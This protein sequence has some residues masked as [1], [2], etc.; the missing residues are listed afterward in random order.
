LLSAVLTGVASFAATNVDD[1]FLLMLFFSQVDEK[2]RA[3]HIVAGQYMGFAALVGLSLLGSLG[4][5]V[6]PGEWVGLLGVVPIYLG[7]RALL[8]LRG[9]RGESGGPVGVSGAWG[10]AAVTFANGA[11]NLGVY[12][13]LFAGA[14]PA[15]TG[16][17]VFVFFVL[18]A[19]WCFAGHRLGSHPAVAEK[20]DRYGHVV[21]PFVLM[22][23][24]VYILLEA[25]SPSLLV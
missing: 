5:L 3:W 11:D 4:A 2:F 14:G 23:L 19:L 13:P 18:V 8:A 15:R 20:I 25:G 1:I 7:V 9:D 16:V 17:I 21:V 10:V 12:V 24:G 6:I 22:A